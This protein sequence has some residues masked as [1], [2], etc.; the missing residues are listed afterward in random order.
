MTNKTEMLSVRVSQ[1][2]HMSVK[3]IALRESRS[4]SNLI[5]LYIERAL[6]AD[7]DVLE[8]V[9]QSLTSG[10]QMLSTSV[11]NDGQQTTMNVSNDG[12]QTT[13]TDTPEGCVSDDGSCLWPGADGCLETG[14]CAASEVRGDAMVA[15][16]GKS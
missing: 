5:T 11:I 14:N 4:V 16:I 1:E 13:M 9:K 10:R 6:I 7:N 3:A 2:M 8:N 15:K 12:Q